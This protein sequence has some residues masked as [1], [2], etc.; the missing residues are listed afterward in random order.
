MGSSSSGS[1]RRRRRLPSLP[2]PDYV[3]R[4]SALTSRMRRAFPLAV[5]PSPRRDARDL[6]SRATEPCNRQGRC[7]TWA[8]SHKVWSQEGAPRS[9]L[10]GRNRHLPLHAAQRWPVAREGVPRGGRSRSRGFFV[11]RAARG[12]PPQAGTPLFFFHAPG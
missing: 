11:D 2:F 1:R 6:L 7:M 4:V 9:L 10:G 3:P 8:I 5:A 12:P